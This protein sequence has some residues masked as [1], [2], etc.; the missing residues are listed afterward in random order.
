MGFLVCGGSDD[1][2]NC[3]S[4]ATQPKLSVH[5][6]ATT[7]RKRKKGTHLFFFMSRPSSASPFHSYTWTI[8]YLAN[9]PLITRQLIPLQA[10]PNR[11]DFIFWV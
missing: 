3:T 9:K 1:A 11:G 5:H 7:T 10:F 8:L 2:G 4:P 6:K